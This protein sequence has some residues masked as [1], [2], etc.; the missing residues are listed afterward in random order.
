MLFICLLKFQIDR[1]LQ[2]VFVDYYQKS[3][4]KIILNFRSFDATHVRH[5]DDVLYSL[6][7]GFSDVKCLSMINIFEHLLIFD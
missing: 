3:A 2:G 6:T 4:L 7:M 5:V 1:R